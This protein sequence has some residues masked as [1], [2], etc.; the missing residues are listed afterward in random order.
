M[1]KVLELPETHSVSISGLTMAYP[2]DHHQLV[3]LHGVNLD[4]R[5]GELVCVVGASGSGKSTLLNILA[6]LD[7][8]TAGETNVCVGF[9]AR[10]GP[11]WPVSSS[12]AST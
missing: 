8:P 5:R 11:A 2:F 9:P 6:G 3:A 4:I 1:N 12:S 7:R 10:T